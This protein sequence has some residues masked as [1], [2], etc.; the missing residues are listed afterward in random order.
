MIEQYLQF[1]IQF[2]EEIWLW[3]R[4]MLDRL[5]PAPSSTDSYQPGI[6]WYQQK[7][8]DDQRYMCMRLAFND[9][10]VLGM[11][12]DELDYSP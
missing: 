3:R 1:A 4:R 12:Q 6:E 9:P 11:I 2:I 10:K 7:P 5:H 8:V